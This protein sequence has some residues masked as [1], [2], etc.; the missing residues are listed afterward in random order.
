M[1]MRSIQS[2]PRLL[3][4]PCHLQALIMSV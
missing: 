2:L 3:P 4:S 1:N